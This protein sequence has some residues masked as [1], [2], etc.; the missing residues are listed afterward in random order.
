MTNSAGGEGYTSAYYRGKILL[1]AYV[2][3]AV[4]YVVFFRVS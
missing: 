1:F 4:A 3:L 2:I